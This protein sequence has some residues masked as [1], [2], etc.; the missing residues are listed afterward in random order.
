MGHVILLFLVFSLPLL[1]VGWDQWAQTLVHLVWSFLLILGA[2]LLLMG[3]SGEFSRFSIQVGQWGLLSVVLL[4]ASLL[5]ALS[6]PFPH[7][8]IPAL[9]ND[10][11][12]LAFFILAAGSSNVRRSQYSQVLAGTGAVAVLATFLGSAGDTP[13]TGPLLNPNILVALLVLT[14]PLVI[15]NVIRWDSARLPRLFWGGASLLVLMGILFSRSMVGYAVVSFQ[16]ILA[17]SILLARKKINRQ[18]SIVLLLV[19]LLLMGI[20]FILARGEWPKLFQGD[21]DR[22]TWWA[23]A[24]QMFSSHPLLGVGPGAFGEAYPAFRALTWGLNSLYAH[25]FILEFLAERGLVGAGALFLLIGASLFKACRGVLRGGSPALFLGMGG[26]CLYNLFHIGFSFPGLLWLFFLAAGLAGAGEDGP[27]TEWSRVKWRTMSLLTLAGGLLFSLVS[28][29]LFR[30]NQSLA[31]ARHSFSAEQWER[32]QGQVDRGLRWNP[33]NPGLYELR[34]ALRMRAQDWDGATA[35]IAR[36]IRLA[37]AAAGFRVGAAALAL[38]K[39]EVEQALLDY[40]RAN[41]FMPLQASSW[42]RRGDLLVGLHR[43]EEADRAYQGALR[44]LS[45]PRVLGGDTDLRAAWTQRV[46]EKVKGLR[47]VG[48]N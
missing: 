37:P 28:F 44:A 12:L 24:F 39:G 29:A 11:P 5:S 31:M 17:V 14:G 10:I 45:D 19:I 42:E 27:G 9:L 46:E 47:N 33:K 16:A 30:G 13:W 26:F 1:R 21:L 34:A 20:G 3:R 48:K 36:A 35:D 43:W 22:W 18:N 6:S 40:E 23:T 15:F 32:A 38:E 2:V 8:A 7:S 4:G 25:N 41:Q